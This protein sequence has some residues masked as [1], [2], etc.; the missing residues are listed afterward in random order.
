MT[1]GSDDLRETILKIIKEGTKKAESMPSPCIFRVRKKLRKVKKSAYTPQLVSIGP[2]H[3][4]KEHLKSPMEDIKKQYAEALFK[5]VQTANPTMDFKKELT[6]CVER[7]KLSLDTARNCYAEKVEVDV[8]EMKESLDKA[9][10]CFANKVDALE[11]MKESL[12]KAKECIAKKVDV[13]EDV[14]KM[15]ELLGRAKKCFPKKVDALD[16]PMLVIDGCFI[17]ELLYRDRHPNMIGTSNNPNSN[18]KTSQDFCFDTSLNRVAIRHD[19]LL[20]ENQLPFFV[21]E[22]LFDLTVAKIPNPTVANTPNLTVVT[23]RPSLSHYLLSYFGNMM[24]PNPSG[25]S[26][27]NNWEPKTCEGVPKIC[28]ILHFL[29]NQ[30]RHHPQKQEGTIQSIPS[31]TE[32]INTVIPENKKEQQDSPITN[33]MP[34]ASELEYAGVKFKSSTT[35]TGDK[36]T[37]S[38]TTTTGGKDTL[39]EVQ[40]DA[41]QG[42]FRWCR[43]ASFKIPTLRIS[44]ATERLLRNL[45]AFEQCYTGFDRNIGHARL[46]F[47]FTS[48]ATLMDRLV[49]TENDVQV[50]EKAKVIYSRLGDREEASDLFHSLCKE[51]VL[52]RDSFY[53]AEACNQAARRSEHLWFICLGYLRRT[54]FAYPWTF[55]AFFVAF[56]V[57]GIQV[58]QLVRN[59]LR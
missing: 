23:I 20:L 25:Q 43:R 24:N 28:H 35:K 11:K 45:I 12:D 40:F 34:P 41:P 13:L 36:D 14:E 5:R 4:N 15:K 53:F 19:L 16:V 30:Y 54:Y 50:L 1:E 27:N 42:L 46:D 8:E 18:N 10:E 26:D 32:T 49:D 57:F 55:I 47:Y 29:Y 2:L 58:A 6:Q 37:L 59:F 21:L 31:S 48:Y 9:K 7:L 17:L 3:S 52:P 33:S 22:D 39:F 44:A 51:I 38:S 56:I